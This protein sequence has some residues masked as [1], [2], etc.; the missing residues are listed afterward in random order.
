MSCQLTAFMEDDFCA[1]LGIEICPYE[2]I[3]SYEL[4]NGAF[5]CAN[6]LCLSQSELCISAEK[7]M[8]IDYELDVDAGPG[9]VAIDLDGVDAVVSVCFFLKALTN[10]KI[11]HFFNSSSPP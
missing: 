1:L 5:F 3:E 10:T 4:E 11:K 7:E 6:E 8:F 9:P 2:E